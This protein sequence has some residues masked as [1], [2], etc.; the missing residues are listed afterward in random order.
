MVT[1]KSSGEQIKITRKTLLNIYGSFP[2]EEESCSLVSPL[3]QNMST[4]CPIPK[5]I[6]SMSYS[7]FHKYLHFWVWVC[8]AWAAGVAAPGAGAVSLVPQDTLFMLTME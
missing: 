1:T 4:A 7:K 8:G 2:K 3:W 6:N 5:I